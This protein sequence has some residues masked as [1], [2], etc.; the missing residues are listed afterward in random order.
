MNQSADPSLA[1]V[2]AI[3]LTDDFSGQLSG[4]SLRACVWIIGTPQNRLALSAART[5]GRGS[6]REVTTFD[7]AIDWASGAEQVHLAD[8][9]FEHHPQC[10]HLELFGVSATREL[11]ARL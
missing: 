10:T 6:M 5:P 2:V 9:V 8:T 3:V 11:L 1:S 7:A 4:L